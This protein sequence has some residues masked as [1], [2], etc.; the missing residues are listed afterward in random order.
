MQTGPGPN[1]NRVRLDRRRFLRGLGACVA[2]PL[3]ESLRPAG[4]F[5][6][7]VVAWSGDQATTGPLAATATGAPLR[8][9]FIFVPNGT[10]PSAWWP[11]GKGTDFTLSRTLQPLEPIR[12]HVQVVGGLNHRTAEAGPD[13]GGDH[14]RGNATFL[15][16]VRLNK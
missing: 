10:I 15:T 11:E 14:A 6:G 5:A 12:Q 8:S 3:F 1:E 9:A 13:G 7:P 4:L 2:L 16:G